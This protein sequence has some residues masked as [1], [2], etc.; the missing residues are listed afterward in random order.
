M[1]PKNFPAH[2]EARKMAA[3]ANYF[4]VGIAFT[5]REILKQDGVQRIELA[6][7]IRTKKDRRSLSQYGIK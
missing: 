7:A 4:G 2:K 3:D 6:R 1:K 5:A